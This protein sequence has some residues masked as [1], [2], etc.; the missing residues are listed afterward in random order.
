VDPGLVTSFCEPFAS[1]VMPAWPPTDATAASELHAAFRAWREI[2]NLAPLA[3]D[4]R[5]VLAYLAAARVTS[6]ALSPTTTAAEAF[7]AI[8]AF[9]AENC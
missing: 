4:V 2:P 5:A 1:E 6:E 3:D 8:E 7:A 9:A